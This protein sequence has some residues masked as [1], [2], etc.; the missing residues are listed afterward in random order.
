L[1]PPPRPRGGGRR[2]RVAALSVRSENEVLPPRRHLSSSSE[3][4]GRSGGKGASEGGAR[5]L[6][7]LSLETAPTGDSIARAA[8]LRVSLSALDARNGGSGLGVAEFGAG[9]LEGGFF[10]EARVRLKSFCFL[11]R[12]GAKQ[13]ATGRKGERNSGKESS[14]ANAT[15]CGLGAGARGRAARALK[16]GRASWSASAGRLF[17][18]A[19]NRRSSVDGGGGGGARRGQ[20]AGPSSSLAPLTHRRAHTHIDHAPTTTTATATTTASNREQAAAFFLRL[21]S[22]SLNL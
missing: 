7:S 22:S 11:R 9:R 19:G 2:H 18:V 5:V 13:R 12:W 16:N 17:V 8:S 4:S 6:L 10:C 21:L 20:R 15:G 14:P 1:S 3:G